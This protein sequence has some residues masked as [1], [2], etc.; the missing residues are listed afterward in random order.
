[1][2]GALRYVFCWLA[3]LLTLSLSGCSSESLDKANAEAKSQIA[4]DE[5]KDA[6]GPLFK[7]LAAIESDLAVGVNMSE[8]GSVVRAARREYD[9]AVSGGELG[10]TRCLRRVAVPAERALNTYVKSFNKW[11]GCVVDV[12]CNSSSLEKRQQKRWAQASTDTLKAAANLAA[13]AQ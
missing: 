13:M 7:S 11:N 3:V 1:M 12:E 9:E 4:A 8:F 6:F 10:G 5:C 2:S